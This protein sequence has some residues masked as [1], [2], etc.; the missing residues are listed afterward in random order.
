[1]FYM[2]KTQSSPPASYRWIIP[3]SYPPICG[4]IDVFPLI[5]IS[6]NNTTDVDR[7]TLG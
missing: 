4:E 1:M 5:E 6:T 2:S 3:R 7:F